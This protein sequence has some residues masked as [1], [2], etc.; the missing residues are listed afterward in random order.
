M[1]SRE[2]VET[3]HNALVKYL[4][5]VKDGAKPIESMKEWQEVSKLLEDLKQVNDSDYTYTPHLSTD[6]YI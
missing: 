3:Y 6:D 5:M 2:F 4:S 1:T